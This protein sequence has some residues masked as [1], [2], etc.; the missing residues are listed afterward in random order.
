MRHLCS[1]VVVALSLTL[2]DALATNAVAQSAPPRVDAFIMTSEQLSRDLAERPSNIVLLHVA[3]GNDY[4]QAHIPGA[5]KFTYRALVGTRGSVQLEL[6]EPDVLRATFEAL[7]VSDS[8]VVVVYAHEGPM[9]TRALLSLASL[10]HARYAL[11]DGGLTGW[12]A[13]GG[14]IER[15]TPTTFTPG[16]MTA[17]PRAEVTVTA[18]WI[19]PRLGRPGV[20]LIDTRTTGEYDGTGNRSGMPSAGHLEGARQLEWQE[21]F[22]DGLTTLKSRAELEQLY[23]SR[24]TS[25]D[26]V[27]TYCWV[28]YRASATWFIAR[29]LGYDAR[30]YDGSYQDWSQ[31]KLPTVIAK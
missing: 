4:E 20:S 19:T 27:V 1:P 11:L 2:I 30:L 22:A 26:T 14:Q 9:A 24:V 12:Q 17:R 29:V 13:R 31:K 23:A 6:P 25:G 7:G 8:S 15:T 16:R 21:L 5:R 3:N 10:G 18:E 28:G